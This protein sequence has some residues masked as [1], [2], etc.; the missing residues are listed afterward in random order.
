ME[1]ILDAALANAQNDAD[2]ARGAGIISAIVGGADADAERAPLTREAIE[3]TRADMLAGIEDRIAWERANNTNP[4]HLESIVK[5][6]GT[7]RKH[8]ANADAYTLVGAAELGISR[9]YYTS[10]RVSGACRNVYSMSKILVLSRVYYGSAFHTRGD[11]ATLAA[12][13]LALDIALDSDATRRNAFKHFTIP[14]Y[15]NAVCSAWGMGRTP[16]SYTSGGTQ[17]GSSLAAMEALGI[18]AYERGSWKI[19]NPIAWDRVLKA[20]KAIAPRV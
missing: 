7:H 10:T 17:S 5:T 19:A 6:L 11:D 2:A 4:A 20:A 14:N 15:V 3:A 13:I 1:N 8:V 16:G 9:A 18:I 12:T